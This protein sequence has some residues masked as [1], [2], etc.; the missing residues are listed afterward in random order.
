[1]P[2]AL[3]VIKKLWEIFERNDEQ[4]TGDVGKNEK[5]KKGK[6][7]NA[8]SNQKPKT[9]NQKPITNYQKPI[10]S[11]QLPVTTFFVGLLAGTL[12]L[13]HLHSLAVLF[14][15]GVFVLILKPE[16]WREWIAFGTGV[17]IIAVPEL[18]WATA[19][20]ATDAKQF[21]AFHF[22]WDAGEENFLWFWIK[23]TGIFFALLIFGIY[24]AFTKSEI[25]VEKRK[26]A[27]RSVLGTD[28]LAFYL[29][30]LFC[31]VVS[32]L[33]KLAPW[34]WDNIKVLIYWFVGSLPFA[35]AGLVWLYNQDKWLKMFA[36]LCFMVLILAG[37]LDVW[38]AVSGQINYNVFTADGVRIAERIKQTTAP[39]A[40]FANAPTY[41][42]P[43]VLSGRRS[44]MRYTG[45]LASYGI[46]Y[47]ER[48]A[49]LKRIYAGDAAAENLLRK[50]RIDY[51]IVTPEER[52]WTNVN[53]EFLNRFKLTAQTGENKVYQVN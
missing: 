31:F 17:S 11:Y 39:T 5:G 8:E 22:G 20:S 13:I 44:V 26:S 16:K 53:E 14:I 48:E 52:R 18:V 12:P 43:V 50:Y 15:V 33:M 37:A 49:D 46:D 30:F 2:L 9:K 41:N 34:Q 23:N 38:R 10:T 3:I 51:I 6:K 28:H 29:P 42:S 21:I 27:Q 40:L 35:A 24:L 19:G 1:M 32:N 45:H 25:N 4:G 47:A 7:V 36:A